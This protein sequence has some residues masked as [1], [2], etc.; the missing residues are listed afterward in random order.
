MQHFSFSPTPLFLATA[1][2][3][4]SDISEKTVPIYGM[5]LFK[6]QS[7]LYLVLLFVI[8]K[9][10]RLIFLTTKRPLNSGNSNIYF[11]L[12]S[13][14]A[15]DSRNCNSLLITASAMLILAG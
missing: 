10:L 4:V 1:I 2:Q 7:E 9:T 6:I 13:I 15:E 5:R 14:I 11:H 3:R 8:Q 12:Y